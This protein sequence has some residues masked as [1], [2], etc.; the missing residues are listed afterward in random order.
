MMLQINFYIL[1]CAEQVN[2]LSVISHRNLVSL[3]GYCQEGGLQMLVFEYLPNG[4]LS[5]HLYGKNKSHSI[6]TDKILASANVN[7]CSNKL[8]LDRY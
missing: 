8:H 6:F 2:C 4:S 5:D 7:A 1:S 3:I